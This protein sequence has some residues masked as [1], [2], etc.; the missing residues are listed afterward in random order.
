MAIYAINHGD[1][2]VIR[3]CACVTLC[4]VDKRLST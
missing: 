3:L 1:D 4:I 2:D